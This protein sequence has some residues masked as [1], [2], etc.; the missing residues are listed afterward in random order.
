MTDGGRLQRLADGADWA[1][2]TQTH[3]LTASAAAV[4]A[5]ESFEAPHT[6]ISTMH[7]HMTAAAVQPSP[8]ARGRRSVVA[9]SS[10][11]LLLAVALLALAMAMPRAQAAVGD[12]QI[13][14]GQAIKRSA[15]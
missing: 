9:R 1:A 10:R 13:P 4:P 2:Q 8:S 5:L 15:V 7:T 12:A 3:S 6:N 14:D 11:L